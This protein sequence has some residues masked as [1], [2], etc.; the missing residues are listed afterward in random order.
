MPNVTFGFKR[1]SE[2]EFDD[3]K[4][5]ESLARASRK[6]ADAFLQSL[7]VGTPMHTT[8]SGVV[9]AQFDESA[10]KAAPST[11]SNTERIQQERFER[12]IRENPREI[13][14]LAR[15][16]YRVVPNDDERTALVVR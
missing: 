3:Q 16:D 1:A 7:L 14:D 4:L 6:S 2:L 5:R 9:F 13:I 11:A 10:N 12:F 8:P 15:E